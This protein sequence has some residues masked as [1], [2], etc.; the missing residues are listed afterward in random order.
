MTQHHQAVGGAPLSYLIARPSSGPPSRGWPLVLFLHGVGERGDDLTLVARY[1]LPRLI[2]QGRD[3]PFVVVSPQCPAGQRWTDRLA[4]LGRLL[5]ELQRR[6]SIDRDRVSVTGLSMGG[7]G[8]W[9]LAAAYPGRF[10]AVAPVCG[11]ADPT[12]APRL[13]GVAVWAFHG[14]RDETVPATH[15]IDMVA[16]IEAS[17]GRARATIYPEL[18]HDCWDAAYATGE[19]YEW[20]LECR[21]PASSDCPPVS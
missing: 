17:G 21:R 5:D 13:R 7:E 12:Q 10:A 1:A 18:G 6:L 8:A 2:E 14:Q 20:L 16:A 9:A 19:L 11:R 15:T 4:D 3:F